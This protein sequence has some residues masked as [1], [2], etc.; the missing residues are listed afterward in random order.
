MPVA[1]DSNEIHQYVIST[2][3]SK[4][5]EEQP[6]LLFHFPT[7]RE[8]RQI[9]NKFD[10]SDKAKTVDESFQIRCDAVRIILCGWHNFKNRDGNEITY[11]PK[12]LDAVLT[13][14]DLTELNVRLLKDMS[15]TEIEKKRSV[16]FPQSSTASSVAVAT[17]DAKTNHQ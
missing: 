13:D 9:A 16:L 10:A 11:D 8:A 7:C 15:A 6:T 5:T 1:L 2:D 12:E 4:P 14:N 17:Q 3:R